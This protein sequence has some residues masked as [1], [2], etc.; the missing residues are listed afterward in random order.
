M[1]PADGGDADTLFK[2]AEAALKKAKDMGERCLFYAADMNARAALVLS[3]ETRL[4]KAVEL[5]QFV[6]H[7]QPKIHLAS[8]AICGM[9]AL[10]RW[11]EPGTGLVAPGIFIPVLEETGLILEAGKWVIEQALADHRAWTAR[12]CRASRIAVNVSAIQLQQRDFAEMVIEAVQRGGNIPAALEIEITESL[13][14]KD[15]EASIRKLSLLRGLGIHI[16]MDDFGTGYS[17]LS[18]IA[19]LP[20][21]SVKIDRSFINGMG[22]SDQDMAIVTTIVTLA[23]SLNLRVVAEGVETEAQSRLLMLLR[24]DEAQ[25][26]LFSRPVPAV[27]IEPLLRAPR[28]APASHRATRE[29]TAR[30]A[31]PSPRASSAPRRVARRA[32]P[33]T[34]RKKRHHKT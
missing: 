13:L 27:E 23:H 9:E 6:L 22:A 21:N 12:G 31:P 25:G 4:R 2:N 14:M 34:R 5:Q 24:C 20:I 11:Q 33:T 32:T 30:S 26:Y 29:R 18:Y 3:L 28:E 8:S 17:S 19:R 16:A 1:F 10:I 15:I 7:Y